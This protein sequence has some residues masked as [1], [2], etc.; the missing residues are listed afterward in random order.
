[1]SEIFVLPDMPKTKKLN[2]VVLM[3][4]PSAEHE[5]SL[6][7]GR[8]VLNSLDKNKYAAKPVL[9]PKNGKWSPRI[10]KNRPDVAF[11]AMHGAYGED[12]TIQGLLDAAGIPYTGS[13]VL[14]SALAMD[15]VKSSQLFAHHGLAIPCFLPFTK[16]DWLKNRAKLI[17]SIIK[18][19]EVQPRTV[20]GG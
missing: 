12:G 3:G 20:P 19:F 10:L 15:K 8:V 13:G 16:T 2:V 17:S 4:G 11:I 9:I 18:L 1:M 7:T 14:A 6:E 5:V